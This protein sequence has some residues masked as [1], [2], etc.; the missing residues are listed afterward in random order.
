MGNFIGFPPVVYPSSNWGG[1]LLC[2]H[3]SRN[4]ES[5]A[6]IVIIV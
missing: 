3:G 5:L 6:I 4:C 2:L 1:D